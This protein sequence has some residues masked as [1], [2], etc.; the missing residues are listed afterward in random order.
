M[1]KIDFIQLFRDYVIFGYY[2]QVYYTG[3]IVIEDSSAAS[4]FVDQ[5]TH[6]KFLKFPAGCNW[7]ALDTKV[8]WYK[9]FK[10]DD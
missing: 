2:L 3:S 4:G 10:R 6:Y 8:P 1:I 9:C 7:E 5:E